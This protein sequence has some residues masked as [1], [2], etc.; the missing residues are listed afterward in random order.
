MRE[1]SLTLANLFHLYPT[2]I[3]ID[4]ALNI[5]AYGS[6]AQRFA[7]ALKRNRPLDQFFQIAPD[8]SWDS[9]YKLAAERTALM[10]VSKCRGIRL[11]GTLVSTDAGYLVV[12]TPEIIDFASFANGLRIA[13]FE[14]N[15]PLVSCM[16]QIALL[17]ALRDEAVKSSRDLKLARDEINDLLVQM[18]RITGF[19]S[20]EFQNLLSIIQLNCD[21]ILSS[22][23]ISQN[24]TRAIAQVKETTM[25]GGR[26][27]QWLRVISGDADLLPREPLD[28][29]FR[30]NLSLLQTLSGPNVTISSQL[31]AG[32]A[33][34][35]TSVDDLLDCLVNLVWTIAASRR[36]NIHTAITTSLPRGD[37]TEPLMAELQISIEAAPEFNGAKL[38][39][40]RY[41]SLLAHKPGRS[42]ISEFAEAAGGTASYE[43]K[44]QDRGIFTLRIPC[45]AQLVGPGVGTRSAKFDELS[46]RR[47]LVVVEDEPAALEALVELLEFEGFALT[48]CSDA[49]T[50]LAAISANPNAVLITDV[51]LPTMDGLALAKKA[52][53][54]YPE[55]RVVVMSGHIPNLAD[56]NQQWK[57]VQKPLNVEE[58]ITAIAQADT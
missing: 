15:D 34:L 31:M 40:K 43:H 57:F 3:L 2:A 9:A 27:S 23:G 22:G 14:W 53:L 5:C 19:I 35:N 38:L 12:A 50:A 33:T 46:P 56:Y 51:V 7:P 29:F 18:R 28:E 54:S 41:R 21:R 58:L 11:N 52:T 1:I 44:G 55:I 47:H 37:G 4:E 6:R 8:L 49:E 16:L 20:H 42:S 39:S 30:A 36:G 26:A 25:R 45:V 13:D 48:A 10:L 17:Q 24:V 32:S